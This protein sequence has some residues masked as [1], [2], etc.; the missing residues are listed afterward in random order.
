MFVSFI[1]I[2]VRTISCY[3]HLIILCYHLIIVSLALHFYFSIILLSWLTNILNNVLSLSDLTIYCHYWLIIMTIIVNTH[4][5][6]KLQQF[7]Y[8]IT[9]SSSSLHHYHHQHYYIFII[10]SASLCHHY[11]I[12]IMDHVFWYYEYMIKPLLSLYIMLLYHHIPLIWS[13]YIRN[14]YH[15]LSLYLLLVW[16]T[17]PTHRC[18]ARIHHIFCGLP[19]VSR[20]A[21][22]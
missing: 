9:S 5:A 3:H 10:T 20:A 2:S 6:H 1:S 11:C 13:H 16:Y 17:V 18:I 7:H 12:S 21:T 22:S 14:W 4:V 19:C 8:I 15:T